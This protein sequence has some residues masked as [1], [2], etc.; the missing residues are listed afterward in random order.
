[1]GKYRHRNLNNMHADHVNTKIVLLHIPS[2][3]RECNKLYAIMPVSIFAINP[4][5]FIHNPLCTFSH[6]IR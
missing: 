6:T 4:I 3:T 2:K 5:R 1:M